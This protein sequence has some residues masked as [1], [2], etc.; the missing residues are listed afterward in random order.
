MEVLLS[1]TFGQLR[2]AMES[3]PLLKPLA[4]TPCVLC[5]LRLQSWQKVINQFYYVV[6]VMRPPPPRQVK[7]QKLVGI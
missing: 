6:L 3:H 2:S 1:G 4:R 5:M 7:P